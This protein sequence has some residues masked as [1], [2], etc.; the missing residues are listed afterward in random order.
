MLTLNVF[1]NIHES[2]APLFIPL[3]IHLVKY[4]KLM[5]H[6]RERGRNFKVNPYPDD[7]PV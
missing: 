7:R 1:R 2:Q 4:E 6:R 5:M 3:S